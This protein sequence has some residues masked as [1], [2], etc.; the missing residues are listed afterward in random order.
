VEAIF[1][2]FEFC[3]DSL[4]ESTEFFYIAFRHEFYGLVNDTA[5]NEKC[6]RRAAIGWIDSTDR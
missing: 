5:V 3:V 4:E 1:L 6:S 2:S